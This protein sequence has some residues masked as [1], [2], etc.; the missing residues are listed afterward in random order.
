[1]T[2]LMERM[3]IEMYLEEPVVEFVAINQEVVTNTST[4][5]GGDVPNECV[6]NV[7]ANTSMCGCFNGDY[8]GVPECDNDAFDLPCENDADCEESDL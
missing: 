2:K 1:M 5:C 8:G 4:Q 3:V 7:N 6:S